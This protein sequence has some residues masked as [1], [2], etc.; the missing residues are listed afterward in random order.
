MD[1]QNFSPGNYLNS[2]HKDN[3]SQ[4]QKKT[5]LQYLQ[6]NEA[7]ASMVAKATGIPQKNICRYKRDLEKAGQLKQAYKALCKETGKRAWYLS[8]DSKTFPNASK[9]PYKG[10]SED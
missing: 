3:Y 6:K 2:E 7:T 1:N 8:T 5:I 10:K 4:R 9:E